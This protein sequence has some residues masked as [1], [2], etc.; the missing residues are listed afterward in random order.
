ME[1][2]TKEIVVAAVK[3]AAGTGKTTA[4]IID[5]DDPSIEHRV[6]WGKTETLTGGIVD[7]GNRAII[8]SARVS[9]EV[10]IESFGLDGLAFTGVK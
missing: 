8:G 2:T 5:S 10:P 3:A 6:V 7:L 9:K 4:R 1:M